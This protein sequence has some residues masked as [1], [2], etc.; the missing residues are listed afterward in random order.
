MTIKLPIESGHTCMN[1]FL[2]LDLSGQVS[3]P[4]THLDNIPEKI[5]STSFAD[6]LLV[7]DDSE[8][9]DVRLRIFGQDSR[10]AEFCGNGMIYTADKIGTEMQRDE[11]CIESA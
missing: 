3:L 8:Q 7:I 6:D 4:D 2:M 10:E 1:H 9:A 11:I 5:G